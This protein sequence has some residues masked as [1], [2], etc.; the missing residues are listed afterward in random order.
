MPAWKPPTD[1]IDGGWQLDPGDTRGWH[2]CDIHGWHLWMQSV[3]PM[4]HE[5][6]A[7]VDTRSRWYARTAFIHGI[8]GWVQLQIPSD[9]DMHAWHPWMTSAGVYRFHACSP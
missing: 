2:V 9:G 6:S 7:R 3:A 1:S 5:W 4:G 8:C